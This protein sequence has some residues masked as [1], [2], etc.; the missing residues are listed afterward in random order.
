MLKTGRNQDS[1]KNCNTQ[2]QTNNNK[3]KKSG[4]PSHGSAR[5]L[6]DYII[7]GMT[8][9]FCLLF[10]AFTIYAMISSNADILQKTFSLLW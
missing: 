9:V 10:V 1:K 2:A 8:G 3:S 6:K 5:D 4:T 7:I